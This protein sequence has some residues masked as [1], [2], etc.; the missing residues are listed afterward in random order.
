MDDFLYRSI[1]SN[2]AQAIVEGALKAG[3]RLPSVRAL[4]RERNLSLA[5]ALAAYRWLE[6]EGHIEARPRSGYFVRARA[7]PLT[8]SAPSHRK[9]QACLIGVTARN[10][11]LFETQ[12]QPGIVPLGIATPAATLFPAEALRRHLNQAALRDP[13]LLTRYPT[14]A[15]GFPAFKTVLARRL[16]AAGTAIA[17]EEIVATAGCAEAINLALRAVTQP[18]DTVL[19][20]APT[21]YGLLQIL[22]TH[23]LK[24]L[25]IP[26]DPF[27]GPSLAA[28]EAATR[29][30]GQIQ[31]ALLV[32]NFANPTGSLMPETTKAELAALLSARGIVIIEDDVYGDMSHNGER[33]PL[34]KRWDTEGQH[35]ACG[36]F[37]KS[38]APGLR[39]G[40]MVAG[41]Y[42]QK[43]EGLKFESTNATPPILQAAL[44]AYLDN[45]GFDRHLSRLREQFRRQTA[46][47]AQLVTANFPA[48]T[49][50][51]DPKG[52]F[53]L[54]VE[55][56]P[57]YN[58]DLLAERALA[59]G[60]AIAPG[61]LFSLDGRF[62]HCLRLNC[63]HPVSPAIEAAIETLGQLAR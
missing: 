32:P 46:R 35:I 31:A 17:P 49:R 34:I 43:I 30:P 18:G 59:Q 1:G 29:R 61:S 58:T 37:N 26:S 12:R 11:R 9:P 50:L 52:G 54:W 27:T 39:V 42:R 20:E 38:L 6:M 22:E 53:V 16:A 45:G 2:I 33:P 5:T 55:L 56:P 41:R 10:M 48:G 15:R 28:I 47:M 60:V 8:P 23:G 57:E 21:Y 44:A 51:S 14:D 7:A 4:C 40:W 62:R 36:S 19:V 3:D 24:A 25:E 63:G 13:E